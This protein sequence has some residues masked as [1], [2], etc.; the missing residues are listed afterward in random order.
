[1]IRNLLKEP[2]LYR[3]SQA[4]LTPEAQ[5]TIIKKISDILKDVPSARRLLDV[6]CGPSSFLWSLGLHPV[7][8]DISEAYLQEYKNRKETA[9]TALAD[10]LPFANGSFDGVWSFGLFHHLPDEAAHRCIGEMLRVCCPGGYIV[11]FDGVLPE[12]AWLR[13]MAWAIRRLDRG[14]FMRRQTN[15]ERLLPIRNDW[16]CERVTYSYNGLEGLFC[17]YRAKL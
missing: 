13:P 10:N 11:I 8:L 7:G 3:L 9:V 2:L 15:F 6:G 12:K 17:I 16:T 4:L 5:K 14:Q 1:M